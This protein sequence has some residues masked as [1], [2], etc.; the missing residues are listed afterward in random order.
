MSVI[1]KDK[2]NNIQPP[3]NVQ[4]DQILPKQGPTQVITG[5]KTIVYADQMIGDGLQAK[6]YTSKDDK[7]ICYKIFEQYKDKDALLNAEC[8]F[9]VS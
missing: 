5:Q 2:K 4:K 9:K 1:S 6:V 8:E 7:T 3:T